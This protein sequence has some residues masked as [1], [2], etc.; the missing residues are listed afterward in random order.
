ML[1]VEVDINYAKVYIKLM[2]FRQSF[3]N[4]MKTPGNRG[5]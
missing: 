1:P 2:F 5:A 3:L 4:F